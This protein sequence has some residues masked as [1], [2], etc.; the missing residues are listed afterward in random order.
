MMKHFKKVPSRVRKW[1]RMLFDETQVLVGHLPNW[2]MN[3]GED[4]R[5]RQVPFGRHDRID[6]DLL[7]ATISVRQVLDVAICNHRNAHCFSNYT[8]FIFDQLSYHNTL[9]IDCD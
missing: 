9:L 8:T 3:S 5:V 2:R 7:N 6:T 1:A 4:G